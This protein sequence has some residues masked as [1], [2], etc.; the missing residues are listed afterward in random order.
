MAT[1]A[2]PS[3]VSGGAHKASIRFTVNNVEH[4]VEGPNPRTS[5]LDYL[6]ETAGLRGTKVMCREGGCGCCTVALMRPD[7]LQPQQMLTESVNS[8]LLPLC[9]LDNRHV[10]TIEGLG[11]QRQGFHILQK[12]MVHYNALQCGYCTP[13]FIM[14]MYSLLAGKASPSLQE[15]E[16]LFD[17]NLCRCTGY[18][19]ILDAVKSFA[20]GQPGVVDIEDLK[21]CPHSGELCRLADGGSVVGL[22]KRFSAGGAEWYQVSSLL[23]LL[24][25]LHEK[26]ARKYKLVCGNTSKGV[27][28][29]DEPYEVYIDVKAVPDLN[30]VD[31]STAGLTVQSSVTLTHLIGSLEDNAHESR[32]FSVL[33]LHLKKVANH[34]VRNVASWAGN[35]MMKHEHREFISDV[36]VVLEAAGAQLCVRDIVSTM[37]VSL[38][39]FLE[40]D[41]RGKVIVSMT[42]PKLDADESM[43]TYKIMMRAQNAHAYVSAGFRWRLC[44]HDGSSVIVQ[45]ATLVFSGVSSKLVHAYKTEKFLIGKDLGL[46]TTLKGALAE[47]MVEL[48]P[49]EDPV[50][51]SPAYRKILAMA[52]FYKFY[53]LQV[54][55]GVVSSR[56]RSAR[57]ILQRQVSRGEQTYDTQP[58][59]YPLTQPLPKLAALLQTSG[60]AQFTDDVPPSRSEL[61]AAFVTSTRGSAN[62]ASLDVMRALAMPGA[63]RVLQASDIPPGGHNTFMPPPFAPEEMLCSQEVLYA[64]QPIAFCLADS[65]DVAQSMAGAIDVI[66]SDLRKPLISLDEAVAASSFWPSLEGDLK[67]GDA[68]GA[69][70]KAPRSVQGEIHIGEQAHFYMETQVC[71]CVPTE[72]CLEVQTAHQW[73]DLAQDGVAYALG[74]KAKDVVVS[75]R[76][77]GGSFGGKATRANIV[78]CCT[79]L[80][81]YLTRRPVRCA[82]NFNTNMEALGRRHRYLVKYKVGFHE[83][84]ELI[85]VLITY[86]C[87]SGSANNDSEVQETLLFADNAYKCANWHLISV[88]VKTDIPSATWCRSPGSLPVIFVM[89]NIIE[90]IARELRKDPVEVQRQN[91]YRK[92]DITPNG[93]HLDYCSIRDV[94]SKLL[95]MA[96]VTNRQADIVHYNASNRWKKRGLSVV[97]IK[98]GIS[99]SFGHFLCAVSV[100]ANDGTITISHGGIE[101]GQGINTKVAQVCA[102]IL[103][104]PMKI[105]SVAPTNTLL[106]P[107]AQATG[108]SISS[109]LNCLAVQNCCDELRR[110]MDPVRESLPPNVTWLELVKACFNKKINLRAQ[111]CLNPA[112]DV[113]QVEGAFIMGLGYW[114]TERVTYDPVSG[115][116]LTRGTW[117]YKPPCS[118]DIPVDFRVHLLKDAPNPVGVLRSKASGEPPQCMSCSVL[119]A[120]KHAV[121]SARSELG[122]KEYFVMDGP[123]TPDKVALSCLLD[124]RQ[125]TF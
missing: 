97:P 89:E 4:V 121:D 10:I 62:L 14:Q 77:L 75:A 119:F 28:K 72:D 34:A 60:E 120:V 36:F 87:D 93:F 8:C 83:D 59:L 110:R 21:V 2:E 43:N 53:L 3:V 103:G 88:A 52:L 101:C 73:Q 16:D 124:P 51:A 102:H 82:M 29:S 65:A 109:E 50:L 17:G 27:Y 30:S 12:R 100:Y 91:L 61:F 58:D 6:R 24:N 33:A 20:E 118:K 47:L 90:H 31:L 18:R 68:E 39:D 85:G 111:H 70:A 84:G 45:A 116:L 71:R 44:R 26:M 37:D 81:A 122:L 41:M 57:T 11:G 74:L 19:P 1:V 42:I 115:R 113:G 46:P 15:A 76:R 54:D 112:I 95:Q 38:P 96:D 86:Y 108:G 78:A 107:N 94:Y 92:G 125:F 32:S 7:P 66:Y 64:G 123:A 55:D 117:E 25:L 5:L 98:Y 56:V 69:I 35:L 9:S 49:E 40:I 99:W 105:I 23:D 114:L 80:A 48:E 67:V 104:I 22:T 63:V 13:G 79:A 106:S